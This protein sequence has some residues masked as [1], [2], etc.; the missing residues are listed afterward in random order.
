MLTLTVG[1]KHIL[2]KN[3]SQVNTDTDTHTHILHT[4]HTHTHLPFPI[5]FSPWIYFLLRVG[6]I[7]WPQPLKK[8]QAAEQNG[9]NTLKWYHQ[10]N[11]IDQLNSIAQKNV[12]LSRVLYAQ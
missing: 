10:G 7:L 3:V 11:M 8:G 6:F 9:N 5:P 2:R 1:K 12:G 4:V